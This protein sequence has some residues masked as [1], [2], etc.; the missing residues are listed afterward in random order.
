MI[1]KS[2]SFPL[3]KAKLFFI[4]CE[5]NYR[6]CLKVSLLTRERRKSQTLACNAITWELVRKADVQVD[7]EICKS[8]IL[9]VLQPVFYQNSDNSDI[10][11]KFEI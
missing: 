10:S 4:E 9:G 3:Q 8:E 7:P 11:I 5:V 2:L 1:I 6:L